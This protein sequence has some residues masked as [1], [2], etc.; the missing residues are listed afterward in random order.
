MAHHGAN[1]L[2]CP[3][4]EQTNSLDSESHNFKCDK[5]IQL[6]PDVIDK[7]IKNIYSDNVELMKETVTVMT[8]VLNIRTDLMSQG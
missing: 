1:S 5:M 8:K 6:L 4:C 3:V 2:Q 7:D